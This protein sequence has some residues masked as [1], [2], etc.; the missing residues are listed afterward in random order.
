METIFKQILTLFEYRQRSAE[1]FTNGPMCKTLWCEFAAAAESCPEF[2]KDRQMPQSNLTN[3]V[4]SAKRISGKRPIDVAVQ[5]MHAWILGS[6]QF[7]DMI[8]AMNSVYRREPNK[9]L[10]AK[11][12]ACKIASV[13]PSSIIPLGDGYARISDENIVSSFNWDMTMPDLATFCQELAKCIDY[14][15]NSQGVFVYLQTDGLYVKIGEDVTNIVATSSDVE[16][17]AI[18]NHNLFYTKFGIMYQIGLSPVNLTPELVFLYEMWDICMV[19]REVITIA[20][21]DPTIEMIERKIYF[22]SVRGGTWIDCGDF[23]AIVAYKMVGKFFPLVGTLLHFD[24]GSRKTKNPNRAKKTTV[25]VP[26]I[27]DKVAIIDLHCM[28]KKLV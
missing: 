19:E 8:L 23:T 11:K 3:E 10:R 13:G 27:D 5:Y 17:V 1:A 9:V 15:M 20:S 18:T 16:I 26:G 6:A 24:D 7:S 4:R 22:E 14:C 2:Q 12:V 25:A 21:G 28:L